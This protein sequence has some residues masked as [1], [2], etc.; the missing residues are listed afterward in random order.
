MEMKF[1][2]QV[3]TPSPSILFPPKTIFFLSIRGFKLE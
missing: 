3:S 1:P 2:N